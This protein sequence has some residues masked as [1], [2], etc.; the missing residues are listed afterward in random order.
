VTGFDKP[1]QR[2]LHGIFFPNCPR[3]VFSSSN[4]SPSLLWP[5]ASR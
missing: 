4:K 1:E 5:W 2:E 3:M